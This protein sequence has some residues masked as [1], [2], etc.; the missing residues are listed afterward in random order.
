[1][2]TYRITRWVILPVITVKADSYN[3]EAGF[4]NFYVGSAKTGSYSAVT[5]TRVQKV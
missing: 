4:V 3:F 1:M 2:N 5:V